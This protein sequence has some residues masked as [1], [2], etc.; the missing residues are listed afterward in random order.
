MNASDALAIPAFAEIQ[1]DVSDAI[2]VFV[3]EAGGDLNIAPGSSVL[4]I[5]GFVPTPFA[6]IGIQP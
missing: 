1:N 2:D 5:P 4:S 3:D 6:S